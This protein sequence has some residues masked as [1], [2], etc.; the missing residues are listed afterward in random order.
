MVE[1]IKMYSK[2]GS[3]AIAAN[4]RSQTQALDQR[5]KRMNTLFDLTEQSGRS[6]QGAPVLA[7]QRIASTNSR[8]SALVLP[9]SLGLPGK[10]GQIRS[11]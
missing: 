5:V 10:Y 4:G 11:H 3:L 1:S 2:S 6:R 9:G 8:F 7:S